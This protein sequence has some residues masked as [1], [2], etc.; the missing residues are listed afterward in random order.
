VRSRASHAPSS[1]DDHMIRPAAFALTALV[2][3]APPVT[4]QATDAATSSAATATTA[5]ASN[6]LAPQAAG[7]TRAVAATEAPAP[8]PQFR[9]RG[10]RLMFFGGAALLT[11]AVI[12]GQAGGI[13]AVGGAVIGLYGLWIYLN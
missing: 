7:V 4:A 3:L 8:V 5:P 2:L 9:T 6:A 13:I 12:G 1:L 11:G 10:G